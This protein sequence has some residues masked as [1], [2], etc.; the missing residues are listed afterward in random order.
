MALILP[1]NDLTASRERLDRI[2]SRRRL[3]FN[4]YTVSDRRLLQL[5]DSTKWGNP[6]DIV[7]LTT[8]TFTRLNPSPHGYYEYDRIYVR[9][10]SEE[11]ETF[12]S[13]YDFVHP[14]RSYADLSR[15]RSMIGKRIIRNEKDFISLQGKKVFVSHGIHGYNTR[16]QDRLAYR[17]HKLTGNIRRD[18]RTIRDAMITAKLEMLQLMLDRPWSPDLLQCSRGFFDYES[19]IHAA[20]ELIRHFPD[21]PIPPDAEQD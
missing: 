21:H 7:Q 9:I 18:A 5:A 11:K 4:P 2:M 14:L 10:G 17:F 15:L 13:V 3:S 12:M 19:R 1:K 8:M 20:M 16:G 6:Y